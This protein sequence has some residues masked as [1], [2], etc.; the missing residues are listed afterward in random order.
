MLPVTLVQCRA[1]Q[2]NDEQSVSKPVA[3]LAAGMLTGRGSGAAAAVHWLANHAIMCRRP[4]LHDWTGAK[5]VAEPR[6]Y[7]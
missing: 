4:L 3:P 6:Q 2:K 7:S 1:A 5:Q